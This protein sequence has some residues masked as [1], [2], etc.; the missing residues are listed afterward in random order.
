M[1]IKDICK[2]FEEFF[3]SISRE[4][5]WLGETKMR[6]KK[7]DLNNAV[8]FSTIVY[9]YVKVFKKICCKYLKKKVNMSKRTNRVRGREERNEKYLTLSFFLSYIK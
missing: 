4:H 3:L 6:E 7:I 1:I 9:F 8:Q 2:N 5:L